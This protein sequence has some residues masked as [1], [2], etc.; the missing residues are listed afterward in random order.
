VV[1]L[2]VVIILAW[3]YLIL[4][5]GIEM[6]EMD[7]GGG[8]VMLMAPSWTPNYAALIFL[9]WAIMMVAI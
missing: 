8:Q 7:M 4:G 3:G 6:D 2:V 9:M 5:A 1:S